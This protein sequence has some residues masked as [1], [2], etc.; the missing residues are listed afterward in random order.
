MK[1]QDADVLADVFRR[2]AQKQAFIFSEPLSVERAE[3]PSDEGLL[4]RASISFGGDCSG[5]IKMAMPEYICDL[6]AENILGLEDGAARGMSDEAKDVIAEQLNV[7][8]GQFLTT[9][10]GDKPVF[11]LSV[12]EILEIDDSQWNAMRQE[13][14]CRAISIE[15]N[16]V[17]VCLEL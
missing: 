15:S 10:E 5:V 7:L 13:A 11:N 8:C 2:V 16:P 17:L 1:L 14:G 3:P 6:V 4:L 12:P 9:V